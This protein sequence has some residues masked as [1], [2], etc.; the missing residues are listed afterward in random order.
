MSIFI[1]VI[2]TD[3]DVSGLPKTPISRYI[4]CFYFSITTLSS[5]GYGDILAKS[6]R[7]RLIMSFYMFF[8]SIGVLS[9]LIDP[10]P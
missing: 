4:A 10:N 6:D 9:L 3:A 1:Y 8:V 5:T 2:A 7:F